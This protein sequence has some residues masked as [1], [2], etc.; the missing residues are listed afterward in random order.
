[1]K[2]FDFEISGSD[3]CFRGFDINSQSWTGAFSVKI[4]SKK[5]ECICLFEGHKN[6]LTDICQVP[7]QS[8]LVMTSSWVTHKVNFSASV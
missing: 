4:T 7:G 5:R 8:H 2:R 6:G 3:F 1:M